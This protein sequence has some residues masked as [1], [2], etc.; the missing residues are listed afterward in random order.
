[1]KDAN[2]KPLYDLW[3]EN[4]RKNWTKPDPHWM[5]RHYKG[6]RRMV[7]VNCSKQCHLILW[8]EST[9]HEIAMSPSLSAFISPV[10]RYDT[11]K[12]TKHQMTSYHPKEYEGLT[13]RIKFTWM[14]L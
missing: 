1:M 13:A 3:V 9:P 6:R 11:T 8:S 12:I 10:E 2:L 4:G 14:L 7:T 5:E